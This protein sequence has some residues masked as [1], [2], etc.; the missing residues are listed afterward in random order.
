VF[1]VITEEKD[2]YG[3]LSILIKQRAHKLKESA[4]I[5]VSIS[6]D[7]ST[8]FQNFHST[9]LLSATVLTTSGLGG[10]ERTHLPSNGISMESPRLSRTINGNLTLLTSNQTV[11]Q[12][13][14]DAPL[15]TL[16]GGNSSDMKVDSL[17]TKKER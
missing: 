13:M 11:D 7:H 2:N 17:S 1:S 3:M 10:G 6:T 8:L 16:D 4:K 14:L 12:A 5:L 15:P 9:E